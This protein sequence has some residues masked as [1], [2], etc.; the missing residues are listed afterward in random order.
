MAELTLPDTLPGKLVHTIRRSFGAEGAAW[1]RNL[2]ALLRELAQRWSLTL[3]PHY[4]DLSYHY[5]A[6]A[7]RADGTP[8]VLKVGVPH[9]EMRTEIEALRLFDGSGIARLLEADFGRGAL[10]LERLEPGET[11]VARS[12]QDDDAAT[13]IGASLMRRLWVPAP[14][15]HPFRDMQSW[16]RDLWRAERGELDT[17]AFPPGLIDRAAAMTRELIASTERPVL[18]HGDLHHY[19]ILSAQRA[20]WLAIDPKG[21]V[22]DPCYEVYAFLVNPEDV[23]VSDFSRRLDIFAAELGLGRARIKHWCYARTVLNGCWHASQPEKVAQDVAM[24]E[25]IA[26]L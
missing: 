8:A 17:G 5:V 6:P 12:H 3:G 9:D 22:G 18:L 26:G 23:L 11:L 21:H 19:N 10:L 24:A 14:Q 4:H 13:A 7:T 25:A 2:P 1:L 15:A 20:P 16:F